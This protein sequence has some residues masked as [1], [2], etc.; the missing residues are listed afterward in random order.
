MLS[1][2]KGRE[3]EPSVV[4]RVGWWEL[5]F[6]FL[7]PKGYKSKVEP[8]GKRGVAFQPV[9]ESQM[10]LSSGLPLGPGRINRI[11]CC[12]M[13]PGRERFSSRL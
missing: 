9:R 1:S 6:S 4:F 2:L 8:L 10:L 11:S 3:L 5:F 13:S 7:P 12:L